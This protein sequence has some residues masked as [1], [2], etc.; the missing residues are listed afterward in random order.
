MRYASRFLIALLIGTGASFLSVSCGSSPIHERDVSLDGAILDADI[1]KIAHY[2]ALEDRSNLSAVEDRVRASFDD[3]DAR[4][5]MENQMILLLRGDFSVEAKRIACRH[6]YLI[7]TERCV[8]D[9]ARLI[10]SSNELRDIARYAIAAIP[11]ELPDQ[12]LIESIP[13]LDA[14][15]RVGVLNTI[16]ARRSAKAVSRV[17]VYLNENDLLTAKAAA[18]AL[19]KIGNKTANETLAAAYA[20]ARPDLEPTLTHARLACADQ[21]LADG[22]EKLALAVY[23][24]LDSDTQPSQVR[25]AATRGRLRSQ[26]N[27]KAQIVKSLLNHR[28]SQVRALGERL[29]GQTGVS[30]KGKAEAIPAKHEE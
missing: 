24:E 3:E 18:T 16:G 6:L 20:N 8:P 11:G 1:Q 19:G 23:T 10:V 13:L 2:K 28:D 15:T 4:Q 30:M 26:P 14:E 9:L 22:H 27:K 5:H 21:L 29:A 17:A 12:A 25:L 7:G